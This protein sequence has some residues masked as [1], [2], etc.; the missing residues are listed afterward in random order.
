MHPSPLPGHIR[1]LPQTRAARLCAMLLVGSRT[2]SS[3]VHTTA[4]PREPASAAAG[5]N[6]GKKYCHDRS[7]PIGEV[8]IRAFLA[9]HGESESAPEKK[10]SKASAAPELISLR[11]YAS[12]LKRT[13]P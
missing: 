5:R 9:K 12:Q 13:A 1:R 3:K 8:R 4:F 11:L 10:G 6:G 2:P 7:G